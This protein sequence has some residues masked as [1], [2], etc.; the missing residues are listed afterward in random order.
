M[1]KKSKKKKAKKAKA[2]KA[3][4]PAK[5]AKK[6]KKAKKV[7][8]KKAKKAAPKK[9]AAKKAAP[10]AEKKVD[11]AL[12]HLPGVRSASGDAAAGAEALVAVRLELSVYN[13]RR[14][15]SGEAVIRDRFNHRERSRF[16]QLRCSPGMTSNKAGPQAR[17][18][19]RFSAFGTVLL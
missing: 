14:P 10:K 11:K 12:R 2:K 1:A 17:A 13:F 7:V 6:S 5:K 9:K 16:A 8:A 18:G 19:F 15:G 4:A 3:K